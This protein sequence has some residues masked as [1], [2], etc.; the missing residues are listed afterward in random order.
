MKNRRGDLH[1]HS[2][3][4]D[5]SAT[6]SALIS[7]AARL[8]LTHLALTD[9]DT[10]AGVEEL[11]AL[12]DGAGLEA[13]PGVEC[14]T[15]DYERGRPA[16][17]LC[18]YPKDRALLQK[19]LDKTLAARAKAKWAMVE[20]LMKRYPITKEDVCR[21]CGESASVYEA[22][23][24]LALADLGYTGTVIGPLMEE[25]IG[26]SGS[27]HSPVSYPNARHMAG[28]IKAAG[29]IAVMAHP[30]QFDSL[31]L[32]E[33]LAKDGL[34]AGIECYHPR[35]SP[36]MTERAL[37][38]AREYQ[39][40]VTGGSDYH[41]QYAKHPHPPGACVTDEANLLRLREGA[42]LKRFL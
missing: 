11:C 39:L 24:M 4:S 22:H 19:A 3:Y 34:I 10:M 33:E 16:H 6:V 28:I 7:Y 18:Y 38:L 25:L 14:S 12:A 32:A 29:G 26:S 1:C 13:I 41:G 40:I 23:I 9:H 37:R 36:E 15:R 20:K 31:S 5:G 42:G 35:N 21:F 8:G 30:G 27:C 17:L 2:R